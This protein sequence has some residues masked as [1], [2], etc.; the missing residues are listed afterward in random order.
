V[1]ESAVSNVKYPAQ[2]R[3]GENS[4]L[5]NL[6]SVW[7]GM[8]QRCKNKKANAYHRYGGR[9]IRVCSEWS[10]WP[11]FAKWALENGYSDGL[12]IDRIDN[13]SDYSPDNCR[14]VTKI[15]N[16][17]NRD[18]DHFSKVHRQAQTKFHGKL[19]QCVETGEIFAVQIDALRKYGVDRKTLRMA[20]QGKYKQAGGLHWK[21]V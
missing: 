3:T 16:L 13:D 12:E 4:A 18:K 14:F 10:Y 20:L 17:R 2:Y 1:K 5:K 19:F 7:N 9:G 21:Y 6:Y 8:K 11:T 15:E